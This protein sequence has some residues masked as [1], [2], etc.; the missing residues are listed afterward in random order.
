MDLL[1]QA[2]RNN[3]TLYE[4]ALRGSV[5]TPHWDLCV[6]TAANER[7]ARAYE[8]QLAERQ[9][10]GVLPPRTK[11][12]VVPDVGGVRIGSGGA[13]LHVLLRVMGALE[14]GSTPGED[15]AGE[16]ARILQGRRV[17]VIHSGGDSKRLPHYSAFGKLFA[18][19]PHE[20]P[21]GRASTLFDEFLVSLT[22]VPFQMYEGVVVA[23]GD[24]LLMFDHMQ[25][26]F[27]RQGIVGVGMRVSED[28]GTRHGVFVADRNT[29][30]VRRFLHKPDVARMEQ[31]G[32]LDGEGRVDV[33]TGIVWMDPQTAGRWGAL[34]DPGEGWIASPEGMLG[35]LMSEGTAVNLYGDFLGAMALE[36]EKGA[37]MS[38]TSDGPATERLQGIRT[39]IWD[40]L[41]GTPFTMQSLRPAR[42]LHFG[43]TAEYRNVMGS[44]ES[45]FPEYPFRIPHSAFRTPGG[46]SQVL[47]SIEDGCCLPGV[48]GISS[49][50]GGEGVRIGAGSVVED[51]DLRGP[52]EV[53][54]GAVLACLRHHG[55]ELVSVGPD[56]VVHPLPVKMEGGTEGIVSR[57]Y[58]VLDNPKVPLSDP[59]A[60]FLNRPWGAWLDAAGASKE[61]LWGDAPPE[62]C[63][64]WNARLYPVASDPWA[65]WRAVA[66]MQRPEEAD[67][68]QTGPWR[69]ARRLS[70]EESYL[71]ADLERV[72]ADGR[73][74]EDQIRVDRFLHALREE[75]FSEDAALRLGKRPAIIQRRIERVITMLESGHL[76]DVNPQ[77]TIRTPQSLFRMRAWKSAA[78]A[79]RRIAG[80]DGG[81]LVRIDELEEKAFGTLAELIRSQVAPETK[82]GVGG[83]VEGH[84]VSRVESCTVVAEAAARVDFGGGWSDTPPHSIEQGGTVLN[85]AV[86]LNG[87]R[88]IHVEAEFTDRPGFCLESVDLDVQRR[89]DR[90]EELLSYRDPSDPLGLHKA[91]VVLSGLHEDVGRGLRLSTEVAIPKG[92]GLGTSSIIAGALLAAL[93]RLKGADAEPE[94]L[95]DQVLCLEQMVTTGGGWQDQVGGLVGGIKL[96]T[97]EPGLPQKLTWTSVPLCEELKERFVLIYTGQRRL[98]KGILRA[99]MARYISRDPEVVGILKEIQEIAVAMRDALLDRDMATFGELMNRHWE[100][101]KVLDPGSTNPFI[102]RLFEQ[103]GPYILGG[104]LVGAGGG[105]FAEV[106]ARDGDAARELARML[107]RTYPDSDVRVWPCRVVE[108]GLVVGEADDGR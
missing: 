83:A 56:L 95:F 102:D 12:M 34:A 59:E 89:L 23:S 50:V 69:R 40:V 14:P 43:S 42:F 93:N 52:I 100:A 36:V 99:I 18:R 27:G 74:L 107:E 92:S 97:T 7:Q 76:P 58:G 98:A 82:I 54:E 17:L 20:L 35:R 32:A 13:T 29:G 61:L 79:L 6:L 1:T 96:V 70:L 57:V 87:R 63:T 65:S 88:P 19:V 22:G 48:A 94:V 78:D 91:A 10:M 47:C 3:W 49:R 105:G 4:Q 60:T 81:E 44:S 25:L 103:F 51:C 15:P 72:I 108:E 90:P 8:M 101:N 67:E 41:R 77:S 39:R 24:V 31:E 62:A 28:V 38:D 85:A 64:L 75:Q 11:W 21:D 84:S 80:Q 106:V 46:A 9:D 104:K 30:R 2:Y 45:R 68:E 66:W 86:Q 37:Y 53:G 71:W 5:S 73:V 55:A 26:D 33:D 16:A